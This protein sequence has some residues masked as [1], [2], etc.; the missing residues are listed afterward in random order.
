MRTP[1]R[2][3]RLRVRMTRAGILYILLTLGLGFVAVNAGNNLLY[4]AVAGL[5]ALM[6]LSGILAYANLSGLAV[7]VRPPGEVWAGRPVTLRVELFNGRRRLPAYLLGFGDRPEETAVEILP[8][9]GAEVPV[10]AVFPRRGR[11]PVGDLTLLSPFPFDM[12]RRGGIFDPGATVLV[13]PAPSPVDWELLERAERDGAES[14]ATRVGSGGDWRGL[15]DYV[16]GDPLSRVSWKGWLRHRRFMTKEFEA[17][18]APP[19]TYAFD[20]VP[21][22]GVEERLSQLAWLVRTSLR[23]GR[24]VGLELPGASFPPGTGPE[25]RGSLLTALA[26]FE[27]EYA[28]P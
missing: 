8:G 1:L 7:A 14:A 4:L 5:L 25:H 21:G 24:A 27:S 17:E 26:L 18:G 15:R 11:Q 23:R 22:P 16:P 9:T 28:R 19:V 12:V 2:L 6:S 20:G 3:K 10:T 13:Y